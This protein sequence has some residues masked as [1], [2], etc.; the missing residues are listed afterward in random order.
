MRLSRFPSGKALALLALVLAVI[1]LAPAATARPAPRIGI[2]LAP[3]GAGMIASRIRAVLPRA[4]AAELAAT[5]ST[6]V[7]PGG[8]IVIRIDKVFLSG[9]GVFDDYGTAFMHDAVDGEV[10]IFDRNGRLVSSRPAKARSP[11]SAGG[12]AAILEAERRRVDALMEALAYWVAR[13]Y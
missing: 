3:L 6:L 1:G 11:V 13:G 8:R 5:G 2:E 4:L 10:R 7:P 12:T 9:D